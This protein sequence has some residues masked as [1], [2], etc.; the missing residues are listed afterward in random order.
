MHSNSKVISM[1]K[2]TLVLFFT[3]AIL[4]TAKSQI[5]SSSFA[6]KI[7]FSTGAGT[8]N[9]TGLSCGDLDG[10]GKP[11]FV[12]P[13]GGLG[14]ISVFRNTSSIGLI[15]LA[16]KVDFS[17]LAAPV[18]SFIADLDGDGKKDIVVGHFT[19]SSVSVFRNTTLAV[20]SISLAT[21]QDFSTNSNPGWISV[22]DLDGDGKPEII[23]SNWGSSN[24]S[25]FKNTS[26]SG[27]ISFAT[28][29]DFTIGTG[30]TFIAT[31]DIDGDGKAD[32]AVSNYNSNSISILRNTSTSSIINFSISTISAGSL[33]FGMSLGDL[34]NDGK[35]DIVMTN[36]GSGNVCIFKNQ[37]SS[38]TITLSS[39]ILL[40]ALGS[41][42]PVNIALSDFD[43]DG[44]LD[45]VFCTNSNSNPSVSVFRNIYTTGTLSSSSFNSRIDFAANSYAH[46]IVA[47]DVDGD[48]KNDIANSNY[49]ASNISIFR[50][51]ISTST[52]TIPSSAISFSSI[53]NNSMTINFSKGDGARRVVLCKINSSVN[54]TPINGN[55]YTA[56]PV[57]GNGTQIGSGNYVVYNDTGSSFTLI[58]LTA[59]TIYYFSVFEFN[60]SGS[61]SNYLT[62]V[63]LTG[64][65]NTKPNTGIQSLNNPSEN[66]IKLFPIPLKNILNVLSQNGEKIISISL[67]DIEGKE[68]LKELND[69]IDVSSL[70]EGIYI[71]KVTTDNNV[72]YKKLTK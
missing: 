64:I 62:S 34:D 8:T 37:S 6:T 46:S 42:G 71:S 40:S 14:N 16:T 45:I 12:V 2:L 67:Y 55:L 69:K 61:S 1:K 47:I 30:A 18:S 23:V 52:P 41:Q 36:Y 15:S 53:G 51:I 25:V 20:G 56:S 72:Y 11:D 22:S 31:G 3:C 28:K 57:F 7:D 54:A 49:L 29:V 35:L 9:P 10:D 21:R 63:F 33:P 43:K 38:G 24:L 60:G 58:G 32:I 26:T 65:Q 70:K 44:K 4:L 50:N 39:P 17:V 13:N 68:I 19:S 27:S 5:D 48:G 59:N 66:S